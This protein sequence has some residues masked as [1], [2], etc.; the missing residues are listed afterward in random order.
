MYELNDEV[1]ENIQQFKK[2]NQFNRLVMMQMAYKFSE[3]EDV[4]T[5]GKVFLEADNDHSGYLSKSE[6]KEALKKSGF[7]N[8]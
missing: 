6:T 7:S 5:L 8:P 1:M 4:N 2:M 3:D